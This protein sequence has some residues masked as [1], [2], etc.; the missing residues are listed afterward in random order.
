MDARATTH[1]DASTS[2]AST[3]S[4]A[5]ATS[6]E[7][8][9]SSTMTANDSGG[10][11]PIAIEAGS[12]G[13]GSGNP[14]VTLIEP[15]GGATLA[16]NMSFTAIATDSLGKAITT[17]DYMVDGVMVGTNATPSPQATSTSQPTWTWSWLDTFKLSD[18]P[19][20]FA[21]RA[22]DAAGNI[23]TSGEVKATV[24]NA[25][26]GVTV[27]PGNG[28]LDSAVSS[29]GPNTTFCLMPGTYYPSGTIQMQS[30]DVVRR[31]A[32]GAVIFDGQ[33]KVNICLNGNPGVNNVSIIGLEFQ[34]FFAQTAYQSDAIIQFTNGQ[35]WLVQGN[36]LHDA[37]GTGIHPRG[38]GT[39]PDTEAQNSVVFDNR[40]TGMGYAGIN[41]SQATHITAEG[42]EVTNSNTT[43]SVG[44]A[45]VGALG[46]WAVVDHCTI[47]N[48]YVHDNPPIA[49][50]FDVSCVDN[51]V[52]HNII[53]SNGNAGV[54]NEISQ[55]VHV[56]DNFF[57]KNGPHP[58]YITIGNC[59][60]GISSSN[61]NTPNGIEVDHNIMDGNGHGICVFQQNGRNPTQNTY[62]HDNWVANCIQTTA[63]LQEET[64]SNGQ[65]D[66][67]SAGNSFVDNTY[68]LVPNA[69]SG[70]GSFT[71]AA[72]S[73]QVGSPV[74]F[75]AWQSFNEDK[76]G[77]CIMNNSNACP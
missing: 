4:K 22:H 64:L 38:T 45:D 49:I 6:G 61:G 12:D 65:T 24:T 35:N 30:G 14:L 74:D 77:N 9:D 32:A 76:A 1:M 37:L 8:D 58:S 52:G 56:H 7:G 43:S 17:F 68:I 73:H 57:I 59:A 16:G 54:W 20:A 55:D 41:V 13:A 15:Q 40:V 60:V 48:N 70:N 19:H 11:T 10:T 27:Q 72:G 23:G 28:T 67:G 46:K 75:K 26:K 69:N 18:G 25:C 47:I 2:D 42:N 44:A 31:A 36:Y 3:S 71:Y 53:V 5:D 50:W 29:N 33:S 66:I 34:H 63:D 51:E 21:V 62:V 39:T